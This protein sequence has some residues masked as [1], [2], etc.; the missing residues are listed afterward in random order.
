MSR[1]YSLSEIDQMRGAIRILC[2][3]ESFRNDV[4]CVSNSH[5]EDR[6]RTYMTCDIVPEELLAYAD[7]LRL[8]VSEL[9]AA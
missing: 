3:A 8:A 9:K 2:A 4:N 6:L 7:K 5:V 1:K